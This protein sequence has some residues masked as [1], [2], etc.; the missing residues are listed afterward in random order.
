M[1]QQSYKNA[2][3]RDL[4]VPFL[5]KI[6]IA[7]QI[8]VDSNR[9]TPFVLEHMDSKPTK[10]FIEIMKKTKEFLKTESRRNQVDKNRGLTTEGKK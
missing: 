8:C 9:G 6:S 2:R 5:N 4:S 10:A 1:T 3:V 7:T